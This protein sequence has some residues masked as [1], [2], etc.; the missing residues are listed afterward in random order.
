MATM[1]VELP[2]VMSWVTRDLN[3]SLE[4]ETLREALDRIRAHHADVAIHLF[5]ETG[6]FRPHVLCFWNGTNTRWLDDFDVPL[7]KRDTLMFMQAVSGG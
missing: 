2:S 3:F 1:T 5:D 4:A 7:G 6:G